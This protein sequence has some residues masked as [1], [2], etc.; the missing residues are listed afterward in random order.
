MFRLPDEK[1]L[2]SVTEKLANELE[3]QSKQLDDLRENVWSVS[4]F[5]LSSNLYINYFIAG[6]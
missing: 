2:L 1:H 6:Q 4:V 3:E 5:L